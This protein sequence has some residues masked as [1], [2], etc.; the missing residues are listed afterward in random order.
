VE[1]DGRGLWGGNSGPSIIDS[2]HIDVGTSK[3]NARLPS[4]DG[5]PHKGA[6][7]TRK[8]ALLSGGIIEGLHLKWHKKVSM[9]KRKAP[10]VRAEGQRDRA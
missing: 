6:L 2:S 1:E 10:P 4:E 9:E 8:P 7:E 3:K 5:L